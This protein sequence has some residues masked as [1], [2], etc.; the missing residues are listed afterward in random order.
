MHEFR[1]LE[2]LNGSM[3]IVGGSP[4]T[5]G[6]L[7]RALGDLQPPVPSVSAQCLD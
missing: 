2:G 5:D 4:T 3:G 6:D 1:E 7:G